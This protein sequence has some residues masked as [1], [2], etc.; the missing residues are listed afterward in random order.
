MM[1]K[2]FVI[3]IPS[4]NNE[5][6]CEKNLQ[7]ALQ[8]NYPNYRIVYID[9]CSTDKT[10][11]KV[12]EIVSK[13]SKAKYF[14]FIQNTAR[15][16]AM[17]N[18]YTTIHAC[19]DDEIVITLDGD[20]WLIGDNILNKLD[21]VYSNEDI[22][23]TY[24]Q[25]KR[26]DNMPYDLSAEYPKDVISKNTFREHRWSASH[27]RTFYAW[28]FK[29]ID[30]QDLMYNGKFYVMTYDLAIMFPMLEMAGNKSKFISDVFYMYNRD[31]I[32]NDNKISLQ[33]QASL[34]RYIRKQQKYQRLK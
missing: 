5:L 27:L 24:G 20:D 13:S 23:I 8:Q 18:L 31:N 33:T 22:W 30:K 11:A 16:G 3:V 32:L 34:A 6:W 15:L 10:V 21:K 2:K 29:K 14:T 26:T 12:E 28:L 7:S 25:H 19:D 1:S 17:E 9:D 4:Y